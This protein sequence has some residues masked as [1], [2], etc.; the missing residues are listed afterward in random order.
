[1][2]KYIEKSFKLKN[3]NLKYDFLP[4]LLE[5]IEKPANKIANIIIVLIT[6]LIITT[7]VWASLFK[8]DVAVTATGVMMP[9]DSLIVLQ[10]EYSGVVSE[11]FVEDSQRVEKDAPIISVNQKGE[12]MSLEN[13]QY[14]LEVLQVQR[15]VYGMIYSKEEIEDLD[16]N[17]Y[18]EYKS[19]ADALIIENELFESQKEEYELAI[20][21][22]TNKE[23]AE[24]QLE[25]FILEH[26]LTLVQNLNS[27]DVK[28]HDKE[29]EIE[30]V[31]YKMET[32]IV[33]APIAGT[34]SEMQIS[35]LGTLVSSNQAIAYLIPEDSEM[36]FNA[37][38]SSSKIENV[39]IGDKVKVKLTAYDDSDYEIIE[40]EISKISEITMSMEGL[41]AVYP[42]EVTMSS[43]PE[44]GYRVGIEGTCDIIVDE[45]SVLDYFLE[46]FTESL[47]ESMKEL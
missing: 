47:S 10:S 43:V 40:G 2:K 20:D 46:P 18:G 35:S 19:I 12:E 1:M 9:K 39:N 44:M 32:K 31:N 27:L 25:N 34:I 30:E 26:Q 36:I 38:V 6:L 14:D 23:I 15:E 22:A 42:I 37:Y 45:R 41:G 11:I 13:L 33:K 17:K 21:E 29:A 3:Q 7:V 4:P 5:I 8:L 16:T 28:I 24:K